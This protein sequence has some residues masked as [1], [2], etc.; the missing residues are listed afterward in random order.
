MALLVFRSLSLSRIHFPSLLLCLLCQPSARS[1]RNLSYIP[2]RRYFSKSFSHFKWHRHCLS[3]ELFSRFENRKH[4]KERSRLGFGLL[5]FEKDLID[6]IVSL[7]KLGTDE[8]EK[9]GTHLRPHLFCFSFPMLCASQTLYFP[10]YNL[11][12]PS[13]SRILLITIILMNSEICFIMDH[14]AHGYTLDHY[15]HI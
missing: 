9:K 7:I 14:G 6:Y 4:P 1:S 3:S 13:P 11:F 10:L 12:P 5:F 2:L 15:D 8:G